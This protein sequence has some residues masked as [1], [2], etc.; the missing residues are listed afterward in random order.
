M[1]FALVQTKFLWSMDLKWGAYTYTVLMLFASLFYM[2]WPT[3]SI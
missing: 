1:A 3:M 2:F